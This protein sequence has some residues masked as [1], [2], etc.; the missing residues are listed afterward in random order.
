MEAV[1]QLELLIRNHTSSIKRKELR[2]LFNELDSADLIVKTAQHLLN[3]IDCF[4]PL[5]PS[6]VNLG[7]DVLGGL[8]DP[9][10][11]EEERT[12]RRAKVGY[13]LLYSLVLGGKIEF[14]R[15]GKQR[16]N[17][18][19]VVKDESFIIWLTAFVKQEEEGIPSYIRP[20]FS[21]PALQTS[22]YS[23]STG[24]L[25]RRASSSQIE[26]LRGVNDDNEKVFEQ[27]NSLQQ[28]PYVINTA[29]LEATEG[30]LEA[31]L[32][33]ICDEMDPKPRESKIMQINAT[34]KLAKSVGNRTFY[35]TNYLDTRGRVYYNTSGLSPQ[36]N[37]LAKS[38]VN[39]EQSKEIGREGWFYLLAQL[40]SAFGEDKL[41]VD[42][43]YDYAMERLDEWLPWLDSGEWINADEPFEFFSMLNEV[44]NAL[45]LE[46]RYKYRSSIA[47]FADDTTSAIQHFAGIS[48]NRL[49]ADLSN[50]SDR[51]ERGD[52]YQ[53]IADKVWEYF[54]TKKTGYGDFWLELGK[55]A[56]K[57]TKRPIMS[58]AYSAGPETI[59]KALMSDFKAK[60]WAK[61]ISQAKCLYL[62]RIICAKFRSELKAGHEIMLAC[63]RKAMK[64]FKEDKDYGFNAPLTNFPFVQRAY[65]D[66]KKDVKFTYLDKRIE[67]VLKVG[68]NAIR[69]ES[70]TITGAAPN[71]IHA[72]DAAK[73]AGVILQLGAPVIAIHDSWGV[74]PGDF[75][76][77]LYTSRDVFVQIYSDEVLPEVFS[78]LPKGD[79]N[80]K[81]CYNNEYFTS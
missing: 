75:G 6:I 16:D 17:Y 62:A 37:K 29:L 39:F 44:N 33:V 61:G 46:D 54:N 30:H 74:R 24:E 69:S 11:S 60:G 72:L 47:I 51:E 5:V 27:V 50:V 3:A 20:Q 80:V 71:T 42:D 28:T 52:T 81:E 12:I 65:E 56:R 26:E 76:Q 58:R 22:F 70:K 13:H 49:L 14:R 7:A 73:M 36:G 43:R 34:I 41:P 79:L 9:E 38:L 19:I 59:S 4:I 25:V 35:M 53:F 31:I 78:T 77:L 18:Y 1:N 21:A 57:L 67:L 55:Y 48:K 40:T 63:Q 64:D 2:G 23:K 68:K 45:K 8:E 10:M 32:N 66:I 15:G